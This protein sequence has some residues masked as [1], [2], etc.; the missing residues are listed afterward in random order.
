MF[1]FGILFHNIA[2]F[3]Q[4]KAGFVKRRSIHLRN[5]TIHEVL[6]IGKKIT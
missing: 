1:E 3:V 6:M 2:L 5:Y 4:I